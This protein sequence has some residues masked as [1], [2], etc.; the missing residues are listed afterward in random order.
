MQCYFTTTCGIA[1]ISLKMPMLLKKT[2]R[3]LYVELR[4][5]VRM[6]TEQVF[7]GD[8]ICHWMQTLSGWSYLQI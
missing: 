6:K 7:W 1:L 8:E 2:K 3:D 5:K 4:L